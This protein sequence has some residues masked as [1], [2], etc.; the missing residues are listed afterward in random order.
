MTSLPELLVLK[1]WYIMNGENFDVYI[2]AV[3]RL[4]TYHAVVSD[5]YMFYVFFC[6]AGAVEFK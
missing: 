3:K 1:Q 2:Y 6:T 4:N 5:D